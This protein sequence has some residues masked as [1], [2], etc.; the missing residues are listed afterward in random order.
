MYALYMPTNWIDFELFIACGA[1]GWVYFPS[2]ADVVGKAR[3]RLHIDLS[4]LLLV[5][6]L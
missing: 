2:A 6:L 3:Q 1:R 5:Q 4:W